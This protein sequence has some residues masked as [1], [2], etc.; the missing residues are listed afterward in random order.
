MGATPLLV[1]T[2][3]LLLAGSNVAQIIIITDK[4]RICINNPVPIQLVV[5]II[6]NTVKAALNIRVKYCQRGRPIQSHRVVNA[7]DSD[8]ITICA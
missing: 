5:I 4:T 7:A 8:L 6:E 2:P 3:A 1:E